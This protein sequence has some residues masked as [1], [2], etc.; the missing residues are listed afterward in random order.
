MLQKKTSLLL[1]WIQRCIRRATAQAPNAYLTQTAVAPLDELEGK[2]LQPRKGNQ[3]TERKQFT[4]SLLRPTICMFVAIA[5]FCTLKHIYYLGKHDLVT[6]RNPIPCVAK[7]P[8]HPEA[9]HVQPPVGM[10]FVTIKKCT[11]PRSATGS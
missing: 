1:K 2:G 6:R 3:E 4:M 10:S 7:A 5:V 9:V 11:S 8:S